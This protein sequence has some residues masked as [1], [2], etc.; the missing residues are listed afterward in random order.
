MKL[1]IILSSI[2]VI[3]G[4]LNTALILLAQNKITILLVAFLYMV[5]FHIMWYYI[6]NLGE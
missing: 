5:A 6:I 1:D 3:S 2:I 4:I